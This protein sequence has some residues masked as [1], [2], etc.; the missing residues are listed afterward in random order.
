M[1]LRDTYVNDSLIQVGNDFLGSKKD[2]QH[3]SRR[4]VENLPIVEKSLDRVGKLY[5]FKMHFYTYTPRFI[6]SLDIEFFE[7]F[8]SLYY[9]EG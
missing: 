1:G 9:T 3:V 8:V 6:V 5:T 2:I 7:K 4:F